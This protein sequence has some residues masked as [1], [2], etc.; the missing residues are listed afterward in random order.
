MQVLPLGESFFLASLWAIVMGAFKGVALL[1]DHKNCS[2]LYY[3]F[4]FVPLCI[5]WKTPCPPSLLTLLFSN[6]ISY[7]ILIVLTSVTK[8]N[9]AKPL[10]ISWIT[11]HLVKILYTW[12]TKLLGLKSFDTNNSI[13]LQYKRDKVELMLLQTTPFA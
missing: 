6:K 5:S 2:A 3:P 11:Q 9:R 7:F 1:D 12:I 4:S 10:I 13:L 8:P